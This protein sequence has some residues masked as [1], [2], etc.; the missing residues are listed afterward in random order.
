MSL[1]SDYG[2]GLRASYFQPLLGSGILTQDGAL[3]KHSRALLR[4]QSTSTKSQNFEQT[5]HCVQNRIDG[6][7]NDGGT[8]DLQPLFFKLTLDTTMFL[9]FGDS[10]SALEWGDVAQAFNLAQ[11]YLAHRRRLGQF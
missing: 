7:A 3:W 8:V 2:L 10:V 5:K 4:P 6:A 1:S 11:D 9:L